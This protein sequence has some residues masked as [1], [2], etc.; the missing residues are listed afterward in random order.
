LWRRA[1]LLTYYKTNNG[2]GDHVMPRQRSPDRDKAFEI[3]KQHKGSIQ[4]REIARQLDI[5]E[6]TISGWKCKDKW[7]D[8]LN[9]VLPKNKR[10]TPKKKNPHG[11]PKGNKNATGSGA[12]KNNQNAVKHALFAKYIPPD[13][14]ALMD[15]LKDE[16]EIERLKRNIAVMETQII[17]SQSIMDVE[18]KQELIR[19]LKKQ[20]E[21]QFGGSQEW[22]F[23]YAWDRQGNFMSSLARAMASLT[24]MYKLL[25]ELQPQDPGKG[26]K[27]QI[28]SF[29]D[30]LTGTAEEVWDDEEAQD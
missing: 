7:D 13:T 6:K 25:A 10:S 18:S 1:K 16:D 4:N 23:Q 20:S 2:G 22:E 3:Y 30:A 29:V 14:L 11:A 9:G 15:A 19:H 21:T 12:P 28:G 27:E 26:I 8:Q 5:P 24:G 17:R